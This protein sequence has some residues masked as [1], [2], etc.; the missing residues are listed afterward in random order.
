[1]ARRTK[2]EIQE[3]SKEVKNGIKR[4]VRYQEGAD[5]YSISNYQESTVPIRYILEKNTNKILEDGNIIVEISGG[6]PTQSTGRI[7][8]INKN[9]L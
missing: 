6:S 7:C 4:F 5:L 8:F 1:M 9:E 3:I 2:K